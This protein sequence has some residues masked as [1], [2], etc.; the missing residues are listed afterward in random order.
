MMSS[1]RPMAPNSIA[2]SKDGERGDDN[3]MLF[4]MEMSLGMLIDRLAARNDLKQFRFVAD[5]LNLSILL[6]RMCSRCDLHVFYER[7]MRLHE[8]VVVCDE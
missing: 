4:V 5:P 8:I 7:D 6:D 1:V 2:L 3:I